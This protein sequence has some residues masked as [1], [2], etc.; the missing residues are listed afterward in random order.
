M[1]VLIVSLLV[2]VA[3][4]AS[5][6]PI[7]KA[8]D[9]IENSYLVKIKDDQNIDQ[10][11]KKLPV[12]RMSVTKRYKSFNG[13][14]VTALPKYI[15]MLQ[16]MPEVEYIEQDGIYKTSVEWG[17]DRIDQRNLPL[18]GAMNIY[19][20]GSGA[21]VYIIDTG[22][23]HTHQEYQG[24]ASYFWDFD[25]SNR[26]D[27]CNGH[28]THCG[29]TSA[30]ITVGIATSASLYSVRVLNCMGAGSTANIVD[31]CDAITNRGSKPGVASL[32][33]GGGASVAM[34]A[35]V[36][37]LMAAGYTVSI[38]AGNAN[39]DACNDSPA[40]VE[41]ALTV[42]AT[43]SDD[44]RA[45]Y[46]NYGTCVDIFAPGSDVRSSYHL[47]DMSYAVL[48]GTSMAC[49]H[50]TGVAA[51]H[52]GAG[53]CSNNDACKDKI[54]ADATEGVVGNPGFGSPNLLLYCD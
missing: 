35:A 49:P 15:S 50:V 11:V 25:E 32:S 40:R 17:C 29:G 37:R 33:L 47:S 2:A 39:A 22:L 42:G 23:R 46:S 5:L 27:D 8:R 41:D 21:H 1:R 14:A 19:G 36:E 3:S 44:G 10:F 9:P 51:V 12:L 16:H 20:D 45:S 4:A 53:T 38:A 34:D 18:N 6:A 7:Y 52:L 54:L 13:I 28:G 31:G 48:S 30:G 26:G 43:D 24:R